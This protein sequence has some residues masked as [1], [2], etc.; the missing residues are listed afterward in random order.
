MFRPF[1]VEVLLQVQER[2]LCFVA[3]SALVH[4]S[5]DTTDFIG[6]M[7]GHYFFGLK[8]VVLTD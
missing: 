8:G 1:D 6:K 3:V 7:S 5:V 2:L 4:L